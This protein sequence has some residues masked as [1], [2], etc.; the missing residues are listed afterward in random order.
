MDLPLA[1]TIYHWRHSI[2]SLWIC[3]LHSLFGNSVWLD[4]RRQ[5]FLHAQVLSANEPFRLGQ[6]V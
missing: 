3:L 2:N 4:E 6:L 5:R 1:R